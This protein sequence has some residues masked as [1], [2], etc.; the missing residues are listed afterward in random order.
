MRLTRY[1]F[2]L[3][4][5]L[6]CSCYYAGSYCNAVKYDCQTDFFSVAQ[7]MN[8]I[9]DSLCKVRNLNRLEDEYDK[10]ENYYNFFF[11][12]L[13]EDSVKLLVVNLCKSQNPNES[14]ILLSSI[15]ETNI[16]GCKSLNSNQISDSE[17]VEIK[18]I[19]E[20]EIMKKLNMK[21]E[22][23]HWRE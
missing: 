1:L 3:S 2:T 15:L 17:E 13:I 7:R 19:F 14:V 16:K 6:L 4:A 12:V 8:E 20:N 18:R 10:G 21:W 9:C 22:K 11:P 23:R 5:V